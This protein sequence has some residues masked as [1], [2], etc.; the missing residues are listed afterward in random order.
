VADWQDRAREQLPPLSELQRDYMRYVL[1]QT[2][3]NKQRAAEILGV[4]R[5]TLY[6]W[7]EQEGA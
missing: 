2:K 3:G 7:L 5:R 6:R 4:T 1:Q